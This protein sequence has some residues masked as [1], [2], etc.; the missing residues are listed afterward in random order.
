M[1]GGVGVG[2]DV[3]AVG[4]GPDDLADLGVDVVAG[5]LPPC[6]VP[7]GVVHVEVEDWG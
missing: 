4:G 1:F 6:F 2:V 5:V 3:D 7:G